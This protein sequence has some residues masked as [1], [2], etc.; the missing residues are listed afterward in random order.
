MKACARCGKRL[1]DETRRV[2]SS[3]TRNHY[4]IDVDACARRAKRRG[5]RSAAPLALP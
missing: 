4:C 2:Y 1:P 3:W 5:R